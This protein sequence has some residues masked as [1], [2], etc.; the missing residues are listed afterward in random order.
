MGR[1]GWDDEMGRVWWGG[2][3]SEEWNWKGGM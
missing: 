2:K 3:G 1:E